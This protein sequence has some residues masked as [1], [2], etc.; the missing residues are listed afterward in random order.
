[1]EKI[2]RKE[3]DTPVQ[4]FEEIIKNYLKSHFID[5][6]KPVWN[7]SLLSEEDVTNFQQGTN[8]R[9][10]QKKHTSD[11]LQLTFF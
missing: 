2:N 8:Y 10:Y 5:T 11:L 3:I 1:M 6:A 9:L 4:P 7:F